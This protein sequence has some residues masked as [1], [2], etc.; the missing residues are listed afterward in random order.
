MLND[1][2]DKQQAEENEIGPNDM[3][4]EDYNNQ[5]AEENEIGLEDMLKEIRPT[6]KKN[7]EE[8]KQEETPLQA[9]QSGHMKTQRYEP[10]ASQPS[11]L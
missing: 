9:E 2:Y 6:S 3:L 8:I 10:P 1:D 11:G 7:E 5:Q 4:N